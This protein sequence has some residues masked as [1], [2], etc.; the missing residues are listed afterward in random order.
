LIRVTFFGY[1]SFALAGEKVKLIMDPGVKIPGEETIIPQDAWSDT[2]I[3]LVTSVSEDHSGMVKDVLG[4]SSHALIVAP[5]EL[6]A[7][8]GEGDY[9]FHPA[10]AGESYNLLGC[11]FQAFPAV[12]GQAGGGL[13]TS[14]FKR[15]GEAKEGLGYL[16][17]ME[18][19]TICNLGETLYREDWEEWQPDLL[20]VPIGGGTTMDSVEALRAIDKIKPRLIVP[21]HYNLPSGVYKAGQVSTDDF[22]R[23][24]SEKGFESRVL[25][26]GESIVI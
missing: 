4:I 16:V 9:N 21:M 10:R 18:E 14:I 12:P 1:S 24:L 6:Q 25:Q 2:D 3:I 11:R 5:P 19:R 22:S 23:V 17:E 7:H 15:K 13:L 26:P 20:L 8:L